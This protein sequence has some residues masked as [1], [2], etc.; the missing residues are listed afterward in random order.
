MTLIQAVILGIVQGITEFL[1]VSS[2]GH[3][4]LFHR[5][6]GYGEVTGDFELLFDVAMHLGT[7]TAVVIVLRREVWAILRRPFQRLTAALIVATVPIIPAG[8]FLRSHVEALRHNLPFLMGGFAFTGLLLIYADFIRWPS[9]SVKG[10]NDITAADALVVGA[11]QAVA[12]F[13]S[14]SRSGSTTAASLFRKLSRADAARFVFLMSIPAILGAAVMEGW[15]VFRGEITISPEQWMAL[16]F[17][18]TAA[19]LSGYLAVNLVFKLIQRA[20]LRYF[21]FYLFALVIFIGVDTFLL[22][23]RLL[24][25][26]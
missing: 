23:G 13:P 20:K 21:S 9:K 6:F 2:S 22:D 11:M 1:P 24:G 18:F 8:F 7:L 3:L 15:D 10:L 12:V 5:I 17:G 14:V 26:V 19:L 25:R 16:A 4:A